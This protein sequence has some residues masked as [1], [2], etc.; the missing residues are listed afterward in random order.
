[1]VVQQ[2]RSRG[3]KNPRVTDVLGRIPRH[4]FVPLDLRTRAYDDCPLPIG[5]DQTIS[6][7]YIV[8]LMTDAL[9]LSGNEKVLE[10]GTGSGYQTAILC[11][12]AKQ[13][14]TLE[15]IQSLGENAERLLKDMGYTQFTFIFG[16]GSLGYEEEAPYDRVIITAATP[17]IPPPLVEQV[18]EGGVIIAPVG[19]PFEQDLVKGVKREGKLKKKYLGGCRFVKLVG[20][21]GFTR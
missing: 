18:R 16:D 15:R 7:P 10:V 19:R 21:H 3:L 12:L 1:M 9:D 6:Q 14:F 11:E 5:E 2:I 20:T 17:H 13:V 8:A 4:R